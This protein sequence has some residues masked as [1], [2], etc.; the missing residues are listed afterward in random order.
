[1]SCSGFFFFWF[2]GFSS[3]CFLLPLIPIWKIGKAQ[4]NER[5]CAY[6]RERKRT[7]NPHTASFRST[8]S[9]GRL[10]TICSAWRSPAWLPQ[11]QWAAVGQLLHSRQCHPIPRH[12]EWCLG[13]NLAFFSACGMNWPTTDSAG[14]GHGHCRPQEQRGGQSWSAGSR[15]LPGRHHRFG[16]GAGPAAGSCCASPS[17]PRPSG[18][19]IV[20]P[21]PT[22]AF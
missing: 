11:L 6:F 5:F 15:H 22:S 10:S 8:C 12:L 18:G 7:N 13:Q 20:M 17:V 16:E 2:M 1:M 21:T 4:E 3:A 9:A 14:A 19:V